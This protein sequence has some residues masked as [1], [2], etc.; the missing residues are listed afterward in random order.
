MII[1]GVAENCYVHG[2]YDNQDDNS[3]NDPD[4]E[5]VVLRYINLY[6]NRNAAEKKARELNKRHKGQ[7]TKCYPEVAFT[8]VEMELK[9]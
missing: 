2:R 4:V 6:K 8:V 7:E 5:P 3:A 1:Y 9:Q